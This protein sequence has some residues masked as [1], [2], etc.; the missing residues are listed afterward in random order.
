MLLILAG[1]ALSALSGNNSILTRASSAKVET[2]GATVEEQARLWQAEKVK[3]EMM[4]GVGQT[5]EA[6]E[7]LETLLARLEEENLLDHEEVETIIE[8]GEI[9][10]G[11]NSIYPRRS[12][13]NNRSSL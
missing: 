5:A 6:P 8:T 13:I 4:T 3:Y 7:D 1:V 10:I 9:T 11:T 12:R 2:R